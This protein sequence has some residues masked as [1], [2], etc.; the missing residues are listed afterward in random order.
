MKG[1]LNICQGRE[2][3]ILIQQYFNYYLIHIFDAI[4]RKQE[5]KQP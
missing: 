1:S 5:S 2:R 4:V 3:I